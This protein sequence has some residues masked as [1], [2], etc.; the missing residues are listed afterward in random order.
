MNDEIETIGFIEVDEN[1][2]KDKLLMYFPNDGSYVEIMGHKI[3]FEGGFEEF[4]EYIKTLATY[5][6]E[7]KKL[8][9]ENKKLRQWDCNKDS[10]NSRQRV[11]NKKLIKDN[12][13][14]KASVKYYVD[15]L[16]GLKKW[17]EDDLKDGR[18]EECLWL[19]GCYDQVKLVLEKIKELEEKN[20]V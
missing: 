17:L 2:P 18:S 9:E 14:L 4:V 12:E 11:A 13:R 7:N 16:T 20:N 1:Y 19:M 5:E 15:I 8:K 3:D 6:E 10:R